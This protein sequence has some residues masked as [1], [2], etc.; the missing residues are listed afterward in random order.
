MWPETLLYTIIA[1]SVV[2]YGTRGRENPEKWPFTKCWLC[3]SVIFL[4]LSLIFREWHRA[5]HLTFTLGLS[6]NSGWYSAM[7][8][9]PP[10]WDM[11]ALNRMGYARIFD[12]CVHPLPIGILYAILNFTHFDKELMAHCTLAS[13]L[14]CRAWSFMVSGTPFAVGGAANEVY[15]FHK[16]PPPNITWKV[17]YAAEA[18]VGCLVLAWCWSYGAFPSL[19]LSFLFPTKAPLGVMPL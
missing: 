2:I 10:V 19:G 4:V 15:D 13:W 11:F 9:H 16:T 3:V 6:V 8:V 12:F 17:A 14:V 1:V 7:M 5:H 18:I